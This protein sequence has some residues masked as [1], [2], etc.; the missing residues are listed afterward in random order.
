MSSL[1]RRRD[2]FRSAATAAALFGVDKAWAAQT[3]KPLPANDL[4]GSN[5]EKYWLQVREEQ[6][7]LPSWRV[8]LNNGSLGVA[9][10]PVLAAVTDYLE[11]SAALMVEE[12]PRWGYETLDEYR[13]EMAQF[14]G[15]K[16]QEL[17]F[18][19]NA[20]EGMS[21]IAAGL[22]L[23]SGDEVV[24]TNQEHPSGRCPWQLRQAREGIVLREIEI[25]LPPKSPEQIADLV[26]GAFGPKTRVVS[27]SGITTTTGLITPM[28]DICAAARAKGIVSV[29]DGA[30][31]T[32]QIPFRLDEVDCDYFVGSP[33]KWL[34]APAG[35]GLLYIREENLRKLWPTVVTARWDQQDLGAARFMM[36]GTN[37]R[38]IFEGMMAGLRF[39]AQI[40]S[41]R[42]YKRIHS[43]AQYTYAKARDCRH[44]ELLTPQNDSMYGSL[45]TM[46]FRQG[47]PDK[48]WSACKEKKI[49]VV[50]GERVR[51]SLH[52]HTRKSDVD[53]FFSLVDETLA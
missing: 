18:M 26:T 3:Q 11:R 13:A 7:Y 23:K 34:F 16:K 25:P 38:A 37:N 47:N 35:C 9:P 42:I 28:K 2:L 15:C 8:F 39:S 41:D 43:L 36:M 14:V 49:W 1:L 20:T 24:I 51:L 31:I 30:H 27:F 46:R 45:V 4:F 52:I 6:F 5:P 19:H 17:A 22:D 29:V 33:H 44:V 10:R 50:E 32:G 12:Y 53:E 21:T 48:L 40:G